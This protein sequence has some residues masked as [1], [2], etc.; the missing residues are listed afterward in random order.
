MLQEP[1]QSG[2]FLTT[3]LRRYNRARLERLQKAR[4]EK[5]FE[6]IFKQSFWSYSKS[7]LKRPLTV[8]E[9]EKGDELEDVALRLFYTIQQHAGITPSNGV[10]FEEVDPDDCVTMVQ[11]AI[12]KCLEKEALCNEFYLQLIKQTTDQPD[13]NGRINIQNWR[14][15]ILAT[16]VV[17]PRN[18]VI[19]NYLQAH[20]R[21]CSI[22]T[23]TEE[24]KFA[25]FCMQSLTRTM[26]TK[27]RKY[28]PSY[29]EVQCT[30]RRRPIHERFYFMDGQ[31]R[32]IE[33][34]ASA[35]T[36]EVSS[37]VPLPP[38]ASIF[39]YN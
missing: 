35:T 13:P 19:L 11:L 20:L 24:G 10:G 27:N 1:P 9:G 14:M 18:R 38:L 34:D 30:I 3:T 25:Q 37:G 8:L 22:D 12:Q 26:Q 33:F 7:M 23:L 15:L 6:K 21:R 32:A 16:G 36:Q 2:N 4:Q 39:A 17:V 29:R 28:P 31:F 5:D